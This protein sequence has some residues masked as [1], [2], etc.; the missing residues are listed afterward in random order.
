MVEDFIT[1]T[2]ASLIINKHF[3]IGLL[4]ELSV[5]IYA[6][7]ETQMNN[8]LFVYST[9]KFRRLFTEFVVSN[10]ENLHL[11]LNAEPVQ[12][13]ALAVQNL[14]KEFKDAEDLEYEILKA[15][16]YH[17]LQVKGTQVN[18]SRIIHKMTL[19]D[20]VLIQGKRDTNYEH[21]IIHRYNG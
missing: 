6:A 12:D 7:M 13:L 2:D 11:T 14:K 18:V 4:G 3:I 20:G 9:S 21:I 10:F 5:N 8:T 15:V 17:L 19:H 1:K 16:M